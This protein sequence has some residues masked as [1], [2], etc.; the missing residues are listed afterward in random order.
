MADSKESYQ[1]RYWDWKVNCDVV[2]DGD[3]DE[4]Y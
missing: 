4:C 1:M 3:D 2:T